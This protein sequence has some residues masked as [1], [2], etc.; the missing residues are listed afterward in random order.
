MPSAPPP[1]SPLLLHSAVALDE[2]GERS[3][4]W[5]LLQGG[6]ITAT[7]VG[8]ETAPPVAD[9]VDLAGA[10]VVPGFIDLHAHGGGGSAFDDGPEA[11]RTGLAAHRVHGTTRSVVSLV[12]A[13]LDRLG[14]ALDMVAELAEDDPLVLGSHL[15]GPFLSPERAGA[16]DRSLLRTPV[17]HEVDALV[18]AGRGTVRQVTLAPELPE[19][20]AAIRRLRDAG[21]VTAVGHTTADYH[22]TRR[23]FDAGARLLTHAFNGMPG[24]HHRAPGP[25]LAAI[26]DP[27][28]HLELVLDRHHV[29]DPV[30]RLLLAAAP[31][32][33]ALVTDAMAAAGSTDGDYRLG[34]QPVRVVDG[35]AR[36]L[37]G[38]SIAGST[39]TLDA[40]LRNAIAIAIRPSVAVAALTAVPARVLGIDDRFGRLDTGFAADVV[41]LDDDWHVQQVWAAGRRI[42]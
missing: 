19:A 24:I 14:Q 2:A 41:V 39:L 21:I 23:A 29:A 20:M 8:S 26:D 1:T 27:R 42:T 30:S 12:T 7:G 9:R 4:A 16:H 33:V 34:D 38:D 35:I 5:L 15:E 37:R 25:V 10:R 36:L 17:A 28:V 40:A 32:R 31:S 18:A 22:L 6:T 3:D 13:S 11:V